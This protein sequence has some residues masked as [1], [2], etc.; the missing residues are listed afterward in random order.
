MKAGLYLVTSTLFIIVVAISSYLINPSTFSFDIFGIH[1]P[2]FPIALWVA[3]PVAILAIF[4]LLHIVYYGTKIFFF[5]KRLKSDINKVDEVLY[6]SLIKEPMKISFN[7]KL[8][9]KNIGLLFNSEINVKSFDE[10]ITTSRLKETAR[11]IQKIFDGK[12]VDLKKAK[13]SR[14]LSNDNP[15]IIQN[16]INRIKSDVNFAQKVLDFR[17]RYDDAVFKE[18]IKKI[19]EEKDLIFLK[20]YIKDIDKSAFFN[21]LNRVDKDNL[22]G[23]SIDT[24]KFYVENLDLDCKDYYKIAEIVFKY[25]EPEENLSFLKDLSAKDDKAT[26][27][28]LYLLFKYELIDK[29]KEILDEQP[30]DDFKAFRGLFTL[31]RAKHNIKLDDF[32]NIDNACR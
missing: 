23:L 15:I 11:T 16:N 4:S 20:K 3:L 21:I 10:L 30:Y 7:N 28:Y 17:D 29:V 31:K 19:V 14:H 6:W 27:G 2:S 24:I 22:L 18:A 25:L 26:A 1:T 12:W 5:N 8:L 9:E 32:I 13:F